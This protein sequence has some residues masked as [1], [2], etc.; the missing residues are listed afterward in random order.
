ME[1]Q[2]SITISLSPEILQKLEDGHY[3]KSKLIDD[4]LTK[5][6]APQVKIQSVSTCPFGGTPM[7]GKDYEILSKTAKRLISDSPTS[8]HKE[9]KSPEE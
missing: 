3:N 6:F 8:L 5:Y 9:E 7:E 1:P 2:E 4:L